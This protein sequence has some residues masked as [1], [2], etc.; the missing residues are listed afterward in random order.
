MTGCG[1]EQVEVKGAEQRRT[2][3]I[4]LGLNAAMF[5]VGIVA[6]LIAQSSGLVAD[7]LDMLAYAIALLAIER[8]QLFKARA[9]TL[10]G[11]I[12]LILGIVVLLDAGRRGLF[13]SSPDGILMIAVATVSLCVNSTVLYLLARQKEKAEVHL[14]ATYIFTRA[15]VIAN[16]AV[17]LSGAALLVAHFRYVDLIV[18]AA[19]VIYVVREAFE[20]LAEAREARG[21]ET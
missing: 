16:L 18:G 3:T 5:V 20:I 7:A 2:L 4:A 21:A 15:D 6:G 19:I 10:S 14:R 11:T 17:I 8:S 13:G 9:A 1:C 12:L